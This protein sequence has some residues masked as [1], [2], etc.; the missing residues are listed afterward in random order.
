MAV[1]AGNINVKFHKF[2]SELAKRQKFFESA[3]ISKP[4]D[5]DI[6][7]SYYSGSAEKTLGLAIKG[8]KV[9]RT[10]F[11]VE[12]KIGGVGSSMPAPMNHI[13]I[14]NRGVQ[15][16][17]IKKLKIV[18]NF[19]RGIKP[20]SIRK[21]LV[22]SLLDL[23]IDYVDTYYL[24]GFCGWETYDQF[25]ENLVKMRT[26]GLT[27]KI[28]ISLDQKID[29]PISWCDKIQIPM[30]TL[31]DYPDFKGEIAVN[32]VFSGG[33]GSLA[34]ITTKIRA[35]SRITKVVMGSRQLKRI[36]AFYN[37]LNETI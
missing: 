7:K 16:Y 15:K 21:N 18:D 36:D 29:I 3:L 4:Y 23:N 2:R 30:S 20:N 9:E 10:K 11:Q 27:N 22:K 12:T 24:H 33:N 14:N 5:F 35:D 37:A 17:Q 32:Q 1:G 6:A 31:D 34:A 13:F 25:I 28:G 19:N 26:E 8:S